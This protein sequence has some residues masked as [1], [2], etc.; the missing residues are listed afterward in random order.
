MYLA[1]IRNQDNEKE[2]KLFW[3]DVDFLREESAGNVVESV[4]LTIR[5]KRYRDRKESLREIAIA[6]QHIS[7]DDAACDVMWWLAD[8]MQ[9][10]FYR[11]GQRYGLL[12]ELRENAML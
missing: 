7:F 4:N 6:A 9:D 8:E 2:V 10:Y 3:N 12:R 1:I 5:G 11:N